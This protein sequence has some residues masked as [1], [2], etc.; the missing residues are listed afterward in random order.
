V[1]S[2]LGMYRGELWMVGLVLVGTP[3][4]LLTWLSHARLAASYRLM[5]RL[6]E[7]EG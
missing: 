2:L 4:L 7:A 1:L 5:K 6:A 3:V